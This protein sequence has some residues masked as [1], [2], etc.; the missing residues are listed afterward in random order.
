MKLRS[1][2]L[3]LSIATL[4]S[5]CGES[6]QQAAAPSPRYV[7]TI[8]PMPTAGPPPYA[9]APKVTDP[10]PLSALAGDPC[11]LLSHAQ[12]QTYLGPSGTPKS[13][14]DGDAIKG[15]QWS[16]PAE[17][18]E[19]SVTVPTEPGDGLSL[20]YRVE[21]PAAARFDVLAPIQGFPAV[22]ITRRQ[23]KPSR[24]CR[25]VVG[26]ADQ[27]TIAVALGPSQSSRTDPGSTAA[28]DLDFCA[29]SANLASEIVAT[30]KK[31][32]GR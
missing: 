3:L 30:L 2:V 11:A 24:S 19:L 31:R 9:G 17:S 15:C 8:V 25:I 18:Q 10:L 1:A 23:R 21:K 26:I 6:G 22:A 5:A 28:P 7:A 14:L 16:A 4:A 27:L 12:V 13:H 32:A 20:D 29:R